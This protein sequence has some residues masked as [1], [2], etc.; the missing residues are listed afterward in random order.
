MDIDTLP[1]VKIAKR[2][3]KQHS[4]QVPVDIESLVKQY[5]TLLYETLPVDGV[6]GISVNL[7]IPNKT[8]LVIVNS[9]I[10]RPRQV[11]TLAHE[12]GHLIIPWHVGTI[13]DEV[14]E[15]QPF[16]RNREYWELEREANRFAAE[17]LMP[18]DWVCSEYLKTLDPDLTVRRIADSCGVSSDA[19]K[20]RLSQVFPLIEEKLLPASA[21]IGLQEFYPDLGS[22]QSFL[23]HSRGFDAQFVARRIVKVL[24][25][26][27]VYSLE[28]RGVVV[29]SKSSK[30][31]SAKTQYPGQAFEM[32]YKFGDK[33]SSFKDDIGTFHW[34]Q[35]RTKISVDTTADNRSWREVIDSIANDLRPPE[36]HKKFKASLN[37]QMSAAHGLIRQQTPDIQPEELFL[38]LLH[39]LDNAANSALVA[40]KDFATLVKKRAQ[41]FVTNRK[42]SKE[43]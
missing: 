4:L 13:I 24:P 25:S 5:A 16:L 20:F 19:A 33:H 6:D 15:Q 40:H 27:I 1:E 43:V 18:S 30:H 2:I 11:F 38:L 23:V 36:E 34:W 32:P 22:L 14:E 39:R 35:L 29:E 31:S 42:S 37:G 28:K 10:S 12:L 26:K 7:K 17:I 21:V 8:P 3:A 41:D 9:G